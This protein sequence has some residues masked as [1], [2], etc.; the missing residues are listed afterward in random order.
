MSHDTERSIAMGLTPGKLEHLIRE[1]ASVDQVAVAYRT[2]VS[3]VKMLMA[4][5]GLGH[6]SGREKSNVILVREMG[7]G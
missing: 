1:H 6:L 5:W 2:D 4:R 3:V 7:N